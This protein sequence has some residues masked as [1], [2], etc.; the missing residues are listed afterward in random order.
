M[1][2]QNEIELSEVEKAKKLLADLDK[3]KLEDA[4]TEFN[5][6][7][8]AWSEKHGVELNTAGEFSGQTLNTRIEII[9]K[10]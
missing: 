6:F 5:N 9:L 10:K 7:I 1:D 4:L 3:K 8:N 2:N